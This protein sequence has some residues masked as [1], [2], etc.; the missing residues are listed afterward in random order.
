MTRYAFSTAF[1][2]TEGFKDTDSLSARMI[3]S[4]FT[5]HYR[6]GCKAWYEWV[7]DATNSAPGS[8]NPN[9]LFQAEDFNSPYDRNLLL[10]ATILFDESY[11]NELCDG[12]DDSGCA[13][14]AFGLLD[15]IQFWKEQCES[16]A[17]WRNAVPTWMWEN[18]NNVYTANEDSF[19]N[20]V[21]DWQIAPMRAFGSLR[22]LRDIGKEIAPGSGFEED[23][24]E[25]NTKE[26]S[27]TVLLG[28]RKQRQYWSP[29]KFYRERICDPEYFMSIEEMVGNAPYWDI[30]IRDTSSAKEFSSNMTV[31]GNMRGES[32][33]DGNDLHPRACPDDMPCDLKNRPT[34]KQSSMLQMVYV[35]R[36][37]T[38]P[39]VLPAH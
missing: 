19:G 28:A 18:D 7:N 20:V 38:P 33:F 27:P 13:G 37:I 23:F 17:G 16:P 9:S 10:I 5:G 25:M 6:F 21:E 3:Q 2:V 29:F 35:R 8:N 26:D 24:T 1:L 39:L 14:Y 34:Y 32:N 22:Q 30:D 31:P 4:R 12:Y 36:R 15:P 11:R